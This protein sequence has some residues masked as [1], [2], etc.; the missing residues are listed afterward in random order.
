[1]SFII[2]W[3]GLIHALDCGTVHQITIASKDLKDELVVLV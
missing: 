2:F 1:L 3:V